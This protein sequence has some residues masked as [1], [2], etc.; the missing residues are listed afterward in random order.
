MRW[1]YRTMFSPAF[2]YPLRRIAGLAAFAATMLTASIPAHADDW[3]DCNGRI[4]AKIEPACTAI[5]EEG[6]RSQQDLSYAHLRRGE[7]YRRKNQLDMAYADL[8]QAVTLN[9]QFTPA[10]NSRGVT[11][12]RQRKFD[13]AIADFNR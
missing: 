6:V 3:T 12:Q 10:L 13:D 11:L 2:L 7:W 8:D 4:E 5:I 9:P 1:T